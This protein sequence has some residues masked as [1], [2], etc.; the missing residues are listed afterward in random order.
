M[1]HTLSKRT[2][3]PVSPLGNPLYLNIF[4]QYADQMGYSKPALCAAHEAYARKHRHSHPIGTF[5]PDGVFRLMERC[6]CCANLQ[7]A[8][9]ERPYL[10]MLHGRTVTHVALLYDAPKLHVQRLVRALGCIPRLGTT[11]SENDKKQLHAK[12]RRSL[13]PIFETNDLATY[14]SLD[15]IKILAPKVCASD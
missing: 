9:R 6:E 4:A 5:D 3:L 8:D 2:L 11:G 1:P 10:E 14:S 15:D 13:K 7:Q 12:L